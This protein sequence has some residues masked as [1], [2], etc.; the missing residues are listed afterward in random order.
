MGRQSYVVPESENWFYWISNELFSGSKTEDSCASLLF[1]SVYCIQRIMVKGRHFSHGPKAL[2]PTLA[3]FSPRNQK[4]LSDTN[5]ALFIVPVLRKEVYLSVLSSFSTLWW[6]VGGLTVHHLFSSWPSSLLRILSRTVRNL[7]MV[8][9]LWD[10]NLRSPTTEEAGLAF[11][12][13][14]TSLQK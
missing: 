8:R 14:L 12:F 7:T 1:S 4:E 13:H 3:H 9:C 10:L 6:I 2:W 11:L 5:I